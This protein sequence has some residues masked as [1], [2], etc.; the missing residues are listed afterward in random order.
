MRRRR[1]VDTVDTVYTTAEFAKLF[2]LS[3]PTVKRLIKSGEI[4]V[5]RIG[6][7]VRIPAE[8][9]ERLKRGT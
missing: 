1:T 9:V 7:S 5:V 3:L 2:K 4:Q 8:E 6:R